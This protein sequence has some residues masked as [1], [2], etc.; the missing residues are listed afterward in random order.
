M[1]VRDLFWPSTCASLHPL[2][3]NCNPSNRPLTPARLSHR[4][5]PQSG[6]IKTAEYKLRVYTADKLNASLG[7]S[8]SLF[9]EILGSDFL[10]SQQLPRA[11]ATFQRGSLDTFTLFSDVGDI[12]Q[13]LALKVKGAARDGWRGAARRDVRCAQLR[14]GALRAL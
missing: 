12:G 1:R 13:V 11:K 8:Q 5:A 3:L 2:R 9:V 6:A 7:A 10:V 4:R 14:G